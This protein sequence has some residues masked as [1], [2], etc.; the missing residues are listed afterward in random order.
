MRRD[1]EPE[2]ARPY[3]MHLPPYARFGHDE[4]SVGQRAG[5]HD[6]RHESSM[7]RVWR[8]LLECERLRGD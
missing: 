1:I 6:E 7:D 2:Q 3:A 8:E 4:A 5:T